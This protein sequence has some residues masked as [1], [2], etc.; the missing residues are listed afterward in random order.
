MFLRDWRKSI[1]VSIFKKSDKE[2][3]GKYRE[4][5]LLYT[6]YKS[7]DPEEH[8]EERSKQIENNSGESRGMQERKSCNG[9]YFYRGVFDDEGKKRERWVARYMPFCEAENKVR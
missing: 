6:A 7:L 9:E 8:M 2:R 5:S 1:I 3:T 4:V